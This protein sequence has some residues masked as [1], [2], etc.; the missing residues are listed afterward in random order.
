MLQN[1]LAAF[2]VFCVLSAALFVAV[3]ALAVVGVQF[4]AG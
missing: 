1:W 2:S 4:L 3:N